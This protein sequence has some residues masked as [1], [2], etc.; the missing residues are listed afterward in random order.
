MVIADSG[1]G[2]VDVLG[3]LGSPNPAPLQLARAASSVAED[4]GDRPYRSELE[5]G[6]HRL[7]YD[8]R[9]WVW[10]TPTTTAELRGGE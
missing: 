8:E 9:G 6:Y 7:S 4:T 10:Q 3:V 5:R 1:E 2:V